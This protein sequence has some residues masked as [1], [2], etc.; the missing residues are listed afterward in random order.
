[1]KTLL[2]SLCLFAVAALAQSVGPYAV[3]DPSGNVVNIIVWDGVSQFDVSPNTLKPATA[4][5]QTANYAAG[6]FTPPPPPPPVVPASVTSSQ[7]RLALAQLNLLTQITV[8][9]NAAPLTTQVYWNY[10][11]TYSRANPLLEAMATSPPRSLTD[12]QI[13]SIFILAG[14]FT[15]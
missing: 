8:A 3:I 7:M 4:G 12:A 10:E 15:P 2:A 14:T 13:D 9:V 1:M 5:A 6:K 11:T